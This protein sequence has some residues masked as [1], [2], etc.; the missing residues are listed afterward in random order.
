[1]IEPIE[2]AVTGAIR[3]PAIATPVPIL[4]RL[5][6]AAASAIVA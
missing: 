4:I 1:L 5:V 6:L 3:V 2:C